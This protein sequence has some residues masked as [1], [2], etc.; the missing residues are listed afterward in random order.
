MRAVISKLDHGFERINQ[1]LVQLK[2][3]LVSTLE[4]IKM[5][6]KDDSIILETGI[7][8]LFHIEFSSEDG[9]VLDQ[10]SPPQNNTSRTGSY[11]QESGRSSNHTEESARSTKHDQSK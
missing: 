11:L 6:L 8:H 4:L 7:E 3:Q 1:S 10:L 5:D 9:L 2:D